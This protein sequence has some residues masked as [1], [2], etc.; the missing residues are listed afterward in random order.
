MT[1]TIAD[2][3]Y[4]SLSKKGL[5]APPGGTRPF[6]KHPPIIYKT[7]PLTFGSEYKWTSSMKLNFYKINDFTI[8]EKILI[9]FAK[10]F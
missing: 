8:S 2:P 5:P 7:M 6:R 4:S 10:P 1:E 3:A 9:I